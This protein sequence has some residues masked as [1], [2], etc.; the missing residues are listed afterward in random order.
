[1]PQR[2]TVLR[3]LCAAALCL[4]LGSAAYAQD[5]SHPDTEPNPQNELIQKAN[6]ALTSGDLRTALDLLTR[7]NAQSPGNAQVLYNLG[8]TLEAI[9]DQ[10][11]AEGAPP[12]PPSQLTAEQAYRQSVAANPQFPPPHVALGFLLARDGKARVE[13]DGSLASIPEPTRH[14]FAAELPPV[15]AAHERLWL[16]RNRPG[17]LTD[18]LAWLRHLEDCYETGTADFTWN[19]VHT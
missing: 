15:I 1:M 18:S 19:G 14:R 4:V 8:L 5:F 9:A 2:F 3:R 17:G 10:P 16:A 7:L 12:L 6:D 13:G 11:P